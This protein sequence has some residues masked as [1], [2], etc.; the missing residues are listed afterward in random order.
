MQLTE[1][2][3]EMAF[4]REMVFIGRR[5]VFVWGWNHDS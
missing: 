3:R 2:N 5:W 4:R 1:Q